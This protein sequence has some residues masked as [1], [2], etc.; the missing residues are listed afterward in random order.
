MKTGGAQYR[1]GNMALSWRKWREK[2]MAAKWRGEN[3]ETRKKRESNRKRWRGSAA[4]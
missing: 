2:A 3:N 1:A 4:A